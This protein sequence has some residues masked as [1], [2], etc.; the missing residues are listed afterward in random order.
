[1]ENI[2]KNEMKVLLILLKDINV[3]YNANSLS[4]KIGLTAMGTLKIL[5]K[6][7][8]QNILKSK[9]LGK[10]V[11]YKASLDEYTKIY[12]KFLLQKEAEDSPPKVK[13][14]VKELK[15]LQKTAEAGI[16]FG[17]VLTKEDYNDVDLLL[18][19]KQSQNKKSNRIIS[20]IKKVNIKN[21]HVVKQAIQDIKSNLKKG[22][23]VISSIIKNGIV[24][25]GYEKIIEVIEYATR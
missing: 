15:Q 22:D 8:K 20:E 19:L 21:L 3:D 16:L 11:F 7:E 1:M 10:A 12:L 6:L 24:L 9:Q 13:R 2:T 14:W 4:K 25:F 17:S 18:V 23:E 5:K